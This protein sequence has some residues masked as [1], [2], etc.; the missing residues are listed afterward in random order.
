MS[1]LATNYVGQCPHCKAYCVAIADHPD[2]TKRT[3]KEVAKSIERGLIV[4]R[5]SDDF[6]RQNFAR[7]TCEDTKKS[8][9]PQ[10]ITMF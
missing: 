3:A 5:E 10:Q 7:C 2:H 9:A 4:T 6:I 1:E 8:Q